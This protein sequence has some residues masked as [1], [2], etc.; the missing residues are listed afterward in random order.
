MLYWVSETIGSSF[1]PYHDFLN[2]GA[3]RWMMEKAKEWV[4]IGTVP[5]GFALFP[6]DL[7]Q[8]R[9]NMPS[10]FASAGPIE[11]RCGAARRLLQEPPLARRHP[12]ARTSK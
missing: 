5:A 4:G 11:P 9:A 10:G 1:T 3:G 12:W 2:A 6:Q 7:S 8:P